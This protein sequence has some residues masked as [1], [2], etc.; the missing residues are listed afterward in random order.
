MVSTPEGPVDNSPI[1][2]AVSGTT[3]KPSAVKIICQ[4]TGLFCIK[5]KMDVLQIGSAEMNHK[6]TRKGASLCS[7]IQQV[8]KVFQNQRKCKT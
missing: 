8:E 6:A 2:Q 1:V 4:F 5:H 3:K 7:I